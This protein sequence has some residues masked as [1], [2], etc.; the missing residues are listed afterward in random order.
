[1]DAVVR[2]LEVA[3][4]SEAIPTMPASAQP[5]P[6][7]PGHGFPHLRVIKESIKLLYKQLSSQRINSFSR[8]LSP[9]EAAAPL[10]GDI[11]IGVQSL[12]G[13][14][15]RHLQLPKACIIVTFRDMENPGRVELTPED[16][17]LV[18]LHNKY[19]ND[20]RDIA[21]ILAHEITHVFLHR[22]GIRIP[23]TLENEIL[24]D[25]AA[26]YLG[27]G[28]LC[29]NAHRVTEERYIRPE[30]RE[31]RITTR[32]ERLG[33][34][35]PDEFGYVLGKRS[36]ALGEKVDGLITSRAAK[37]AFDKGSRL[38]VAD[39]RSA[40]VVGCGWWR[41]WGYSWNRRYIRNAHQKSGLTG[42]SRQFG[43]YQFEVTD[44]MRV[45][46]DCPV[47]SQKLRLP[48][49]KRVVARCSI[50]ETSFECST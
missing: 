6:A 26:V 14:I 31:V 29:L 21:A 44:S 23:D 17:Y 32:D 48:T 8:S 34:L 43:G 42:F 15:V 7:T 25:T 13:V 19:R 46:F 9:T 10:G 36:L 11:I 33:Y 2:R 22:H 41:R 38:A 24:T 16:D 18:D 45:I 28:W 20:H 50:C 30:V 40:P 49:D 47:C 4:V 37:L 39:H 1:V 12:A 5:T 3:A 35:T 27:V